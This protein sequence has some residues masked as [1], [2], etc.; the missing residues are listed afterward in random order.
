VPA[1]IPGYPERDVYV[2]DVTFGIAWYQR[3]HWADRLAAI[4]ADI[5]A[6]QQKTAAG[7]SGDARDQDLYDR[8]LASTTVRPV[9][10]AT[11]RHTPP[12]PFR[13]AEPL[14]IG[15][16]VADASL[17][18]TLRYRRVNQAEPWQAVRMTR[19]ASRHTAVIPA[20]YTDSVFPL[21]YYFELRGGSP[22]GARLYPGFD[23]GWS[24]PPY[25]V[26]RQSARA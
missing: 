24:G 18:V 26:V 8:L 22:P 19:E 2:E 13:R 23:A 21:Q 12:P 5:A 17:D 20:P 6:M 11:V 15:I 16:V 7:G 25:L 1:L 4:D 10:S 14:S 9:R 3:G